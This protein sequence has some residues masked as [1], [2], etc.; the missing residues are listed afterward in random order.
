MP[1]AASILSGL[2][3]F[4]L[5]TLYIA[6]L[7][8]LILKPETASQ[9]SSDYDADSNHHDEAESEPRAEFNHTQRT[10][11]IEIDSITCS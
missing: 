4:P 3:I 11:E 9:G 8:Y 2:L 6:L 5:I 1:K 7:A 10:G